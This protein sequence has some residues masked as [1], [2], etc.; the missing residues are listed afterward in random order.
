MDDCNMDEFPKTPC[1]KH[2]STVNRTV[3]R[4]D[5]KINRCKFQDIAN[6]NLI[7]LSLEEKEWEIYKNFPCKNLVEGTPTT[8]YGN[9][10]DPKELPI[11]LCILFKIDTLANH[12]SSYNLT[13]LQLEPHNPQK[14]AGL[15]NSE[16]SKQFAIG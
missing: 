8:E 11:N 9:E 5:R 3:H 4:K 6:F 13:Q 14:I 15:T 12:P 10:S 1:V 2:A 16:Q 7:L